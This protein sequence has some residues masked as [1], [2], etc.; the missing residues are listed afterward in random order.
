[1]GRR[2]S[3]SARPT[4]MTDRAQGGG[5]YQIRRTAQRDGSYLEKGK[6]PESLSLVTS[7]ATGKQGADGAG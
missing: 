7:A 6:R 4:L 2:G 3:G 5:S 1:M